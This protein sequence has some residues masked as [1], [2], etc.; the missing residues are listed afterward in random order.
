M[1]ATSPGDS[2]VFPAFQS[3]HEIAE[4]DVT[5]ISR[6]GVS[7]LILLELS[8]VP[9]ESFFKALFGTWHEGIRFVTYL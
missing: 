6:E 1:S 9:K 8:G 3:K 4:D 7:D 5:S 2:G